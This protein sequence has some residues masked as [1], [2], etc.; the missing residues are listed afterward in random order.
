MAELFDDRLPET[1]RRGRGSAVN[2]AGRYERLTTE[3]FDDG[4]PAGEEAAPLRTSVSVDASRSILAR[5]TSPDVPFDR[6]INPYRG[7][8]HGCVY[9]FARPTHAH[10]GLSPGL[11]FETRLVIKPR[12][13]D[14]LEQALRRPGYD[15]RPIAIGT[16]TDPYQP[17]ERDHRI[18]RRILEVLEAYRHPVTITTKGAAITDD[19]DVLG[20]MGRAGLAR[21]TVSLTT[22]D[23]RVSRAM[24]P[25]AAAPGRRIAAIRALARAGV[26]VGVN[27]APVVPGLTCHELEKLMEAGAEAGA[28]FAAWIALRLPME[29]SGLFREWLERAFPDRAAKIM[30]R[31]REMHGGRDYDP[32]WGRRLTGEGVHA[33][34]IAR[35]FEVARDRL[36]LGRRPSPLRCELFSPPPRAGDQLALF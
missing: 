6:S 21:V 35:R 13:P 34:L 3:S 1:A 18:M 30:G 5:N 2:P 9:C 33:R 16:N 19:L 32:A 25:R 22:L 8:E 36:G 31:V 26:P 27:I 7:C 24:E 12:A 17:I 29:V 23:P 20:R 11:D 14:L 10:L 4:W 15:C 28:S